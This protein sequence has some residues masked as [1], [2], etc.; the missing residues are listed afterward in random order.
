LVAAARSSA[1]LMATLRGSSERLARL[2]L[3]MTQDVA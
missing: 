1:S 2:K 3:G